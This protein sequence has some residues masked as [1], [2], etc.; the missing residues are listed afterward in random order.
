MNYILVG[1]MIY[2]T[3]VVVI[4]SFILHKLGDKLNCNIPDYKCTS[5]PTITPMT[6]ETKTIRHNKVKRRFFPRSR[7]YLK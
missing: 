1:G 5:Y 7:K 4:I 2:M 6:W 3:L